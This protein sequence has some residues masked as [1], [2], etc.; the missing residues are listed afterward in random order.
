MSLAD[1]RRVILAELARRQADDPTTEQQVQ[2]A[3]GPYA[4]CVEATFTSDGEMV[5]VGS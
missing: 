5:E 2:I 4:Q 1:E 3:L